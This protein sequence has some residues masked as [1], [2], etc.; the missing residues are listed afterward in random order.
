MSQDFDFIGGHYLQAITE[1][2]VLIGVPFTERI[3][4]LK[5][6][7]VVIVTYNNPNREL[8]EYILKET[9]KMTDKVHLVGDVSG[10]NGVQA[11]I[12]QAANLTRA[13]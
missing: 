8:A 3:R 4:T 2:E 10:T 11:A 12:H 1:D 9:P 13:I 6:K 5:A 7:M